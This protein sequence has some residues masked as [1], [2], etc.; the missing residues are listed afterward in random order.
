MKPKLLLI[1]DNDDDARVAISSLTEA[2][3][4]FDYVHVRRLVDAMWELEGTPKN[5]YQKIYL[6][7]GLSEVKGQAQSVINSLAKYVGR[8]NIIA[9]TGHPQSGTSQKI[10][11]GGIQVLGKEPF[12]YSDSN[13]LASLFFNQQIN[14]DKSV[15]RHKELARLEIKIATLEQEIDIKSES[16]LQYRTQLMA[17]VKELK[18]DLG[19]LED[20]M[21]VLEIQTVNTSTLNIKRFEVHWQLLIALIATSAG[22]TLTAIAPRLVEMFQHKP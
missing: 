21:N 14:H 19:L 11:E 8:E 20:R 3:E 1:E 6:D 18:S 5:T 16:D 12:K 22:A 15:A 9:V 10:R 7:L 4:E 17:L 2:G 13:L